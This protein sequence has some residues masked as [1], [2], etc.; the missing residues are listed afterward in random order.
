[1]PPPR[2][3][4]LE[5]IAEASQKKSHF[6]VAYRRISSSSFT[7]IV[8][9]TLGKPRSEY[10]WCSTVALQC[11]G[12]VS[13]C[14]QK[15]C[16]SASSV[17][18]QCSDNGSNRNQRAEH[19]LSSRLLLVICHSLARNWRDYFKTMSVFMLVQ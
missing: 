18:N 1:M 19:E 14:S 9:E 10:R 6:E 2:S 11:V 8:T 5:K 12:M 15:H 3:R 4:M 16:K 13:G 7:A 17:S